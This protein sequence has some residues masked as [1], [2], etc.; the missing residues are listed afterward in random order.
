MR[1]MRLGRMAWAGLLSLAASAAA[2]PARAAA[3]LVMNGDFEQTTLTSSGQFQAS[4]VTGWSTSGYNFIYFPGTA[5]VGGAN[6]VQY[7]CCT[8]L[9]GPNDG[10]ANGLPATSPTGGNFVGADGAF[11]VGAITQTVT[12]L[13]IGA[14]YFLSFYWAA[15]Q[16]QGYTGATTES[17]NVSFGSSSYNTATVTTPSM[18]FSPWRVETT[19]FQATATSQVLSFLAAGTP[20][21]QPPFSLLDGVSLTV[22]EPAT[23]VALLAA[24][25]AFQAVASAGAPRRSRTRGAP[26]DA[27]PGSAPGNATRSIRVSALA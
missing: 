26:A 16:Q 27:T 7:G 5:D 15:G 25:T 24:L 22:P 18:G 10:S 6:T 19:T 20:G 14:D 9:W 4:N 2:Q 17:W 1:Q 3:N 8:K 23:W 11:S 13:T 12:G 21:G